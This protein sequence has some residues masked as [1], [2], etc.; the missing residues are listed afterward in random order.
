MEFYHEI[1]NEVLLC[2]VPFVYNFRYKMHSFR[3][4]KTPACGSSGIYEFDKTSIEKFTLLEIREMLYHLV[5]YVKD[6]L[7][8]SKIQIVINMIEKDMTGAQGGEAGSS[9]L[10]IKYSD[11]LAAY[12][13]LK[14][15]YDRICA[16][17]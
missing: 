3:K 16:A 7:H 6:P 5:I 13:E 11:L 12:S 17:F 8:I 1:V 15:K 4:Y 10:L 14:G 2:V 9:S